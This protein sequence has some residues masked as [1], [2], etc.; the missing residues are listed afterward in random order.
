MAIPVSQ[1]APMLPRSGLPDCVHAP[2]V[3]RLLL[4]GVLGQ[5]ERQAAAAML[6]GARVMEECGGC[7]QSSGDSA[8]LVKVQSLSFYR[9]TK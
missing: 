9:S 4:A 2:S 6:Q 1:S 3:R 7:G 5:G 8:V